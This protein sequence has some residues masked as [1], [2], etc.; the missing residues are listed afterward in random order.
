MEN[1]SKALIIAGSILIA[2]I[3]IAYGIKVVS[4]SAK[5]SESVSTTMETSEINM[6]N[7]QFSHYLGLNR[8]KAQVI[9]FLNAIN[10]YNAK[11]SDS[12][13][14]SIHI[15]GKRIKGAFTILDFAN[16]NLQ[17]DKQYEIDVVKVNAEGLVSEYAIRN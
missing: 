16:K 7:N 17:E 4:S 12:S 11:V 6:I 15:F 1:A 9:S 8:S 3:L 13:Q 14:I 10:A 5:T 2:L